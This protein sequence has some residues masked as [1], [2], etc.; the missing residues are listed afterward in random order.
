MGAQGWTSD[1]KEANKSPGGKQALLTNLLKGG[2]ES[3][4][5][6]IKNPR[7]EEW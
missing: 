7:G 2:S 4:S 1:P 6:P 5:K 3:Q